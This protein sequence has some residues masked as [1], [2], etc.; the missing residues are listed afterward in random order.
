VSAIV[1]SS[2]RTAVRAVVIVDGRLLAVK[3][4]DRD[5][6]FYILPGGGQKPGETF[7]DT[8]HRECVEEIGASVRIGDF[9][10]V[11]EY[12]G[13]N[14]DF[15]YRHANFHQVESVFR[16]YI[17]DLSTVRTGDEHDM[18]QVGVEWLPLNTLAM[19]RFFPKILADYIKDGEIVV[20]QH[21]LGDVN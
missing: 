1:S 16:C 10:F 15:S 13:K 6:I 18:R 9:L 19:S 5:G 12:I 8:L 3:M 17:D 2:I 20:P 11:R 21:Y 7:F 4:K 14:H